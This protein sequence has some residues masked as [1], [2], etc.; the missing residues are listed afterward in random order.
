MILA[1]ALI[2]YVEYSYYSRLVLELWPE[3]QAI[4]SAALNSFLVLMLLWSL[5]AT[6][7]LDPGYVSTYYDGRREDSALIMS[8]KG[9]AEPLI[10]VR[11]VENASC[12]LYRYCN[13]C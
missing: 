12:F 13:K 4:V 10:K 1:L 5:L 6:Y 7:F 11:E 9:S 2:A 8:V 3:T